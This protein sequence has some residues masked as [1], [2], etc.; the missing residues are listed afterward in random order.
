MRT[1]V[2]QYGS[3]W[4]RTPL[5]A[6]CDGSGRDSV[7]SPLGIIPLTLCVSC[8]PSSSHHSHPRSR[9]PRSPPR[10]H[11][12]PQADHPMG[13]A[14]PG[15]QRRPDH[16]RICTAGVRSVGQKYGVSRQLFDASPHTIFSHPP[17]HT[18]TWSQAGSTIITVSVCTPPL[19]PNHPLPSHTDTGPQGRQYH[20]CLHTC[21]GG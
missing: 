17:T 7:C 19:A 18:D 21:G 3:R 6:H 2:R 14:G 4:R 15:L 8:H 13:A 16:L 10:L 5:C 9:C 11:P 20:H 12:R 1:T